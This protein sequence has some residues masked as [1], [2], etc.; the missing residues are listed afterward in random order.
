MFKTALAKAVFL[1][2]SIVVAVFNMFKLFV[3]LNKFEL[4]G[5]YSYRLTKY[6]F[7]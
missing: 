4:L 5:I 3:F 1:K 6:G 7:I 2:P